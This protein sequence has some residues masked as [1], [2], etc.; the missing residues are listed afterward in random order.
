MSTQKRIPLRRLTASA[1]IAAMAAGALAVAPVATTPAAAATPVTITPNP[2]YAH[3]E[4]KGWGTSLVWFANATG[5]Y[6]LSDNAEANQLADDFYDLLFSEDGLD[7]EAVRYNIGGGNSSDTVDYLRPGG[8]VEGW[9]APDPDG[10]LGLYNGRATTYA[11]YSD[12]L[13]E[14]DPDDDAHYNFDADLS[15]RWW[16]ERLQES[17]QVKNWEFFSNSAP[18]FMTNSGYVSGHWRGSSNDQLAGNGQET[19]SAINAT[20]KFAK[21][22]ARVTRYLTEEYGIVPD[23]VEPFNEPNDCGNCW[24]TDGSAGSPQ[25]RQEGMSVKA[26]QQTRVIRELR[27]AL[28]SQ[29]LTT[30]DGKNLVSA[31]DASSSVNFRADFTGSNNGN[32]GYLQNGN[33][34]VDALGQFNTHGYGDQ[35]HARWIRDVAKSYGKPLYQS[36]F[37]GDYSGTG[38]NPYN[39]NNGLNFATRIN[40]QMAQYEPNSWALWQPVEDYYNMEQ[41]SS[42]G[43][44]NLNW[45]SIFI[46]FDCSV[47]TRENGS[48]VFASDRRVERLYGGVNAQGRVSNEVPSCTTATNSKFNTLK[49]YTHFIKAGDTVVA[50]NSADATA[51]VREAD[52]SLRVVYTNTDTTTR[53]VTLDLSGFAEIAPGATV[54]KYVTTAAPQGGPTTANTLVHDSDE[55]VTVN[56]SAKSAALEVPGRSVTTFVV[57]G[58]SGVSAEAP[59]VTDG[60][61]YQIVAQS[62]GV[63]LSANAT[64]SGV[65]VASG[66]SPISQKWTLTQV[67]VSEA[68][69][70][71]RAYVISNNNGAV[72]VGSSSGVSTTTALTVSDAIDDASAVWFLNSTDGQRFSFVNKAQI[73]ALNVS[74]TAVGLQDSNGAASQGWTVRDLSVTA[75][76]TVSVATSV[77][78]APV[79]PETVLPKY[80]WGDGAAAPVVWQLPNPSVWGQAGRVTVQGTA[81]DG[82]G[83]EFDVQALVDVGHFTLTDPASVSVSAGTTLAAVTAAA[84]TSVGARIGSSTPYPASVTWDWTGISDAAFAAVGVVTVPGTASSNEAGAPGLPAQLSVIVTT[85]QPTN[86]APLSTTTASATYTEKPEFTVDNTRNGVLTDKGWSNWRQGTQNASDTLTYEFAANEHLESAKVYFWKDGT[87]SS[88]PQSLKAQYR[89]AAGAW[90][91]VPG[92]ETAQPVTSPADGTAPVV[93]IPIGGIDATALRVVLNA[94]SNTHMIVSEVQ[95]FA[96]RRGPA[97]VASLAALRA[98]GTD[99]AGF[100]ADTL[101]YTVPVGASELAEGTFPTLTALPVDAAA[102]VTITPATTGHPTATVTVR[103]EDGTTTKAYTVTFVAGEDTLDVAGA[104]TTR[105]VAGR[106]V[107]AV[108]LTNNEDQPVAAR[109]TTAYGAKDIAALRADGSVSSAFTARVAGIPAGEATAVFTAGDRTRTLSLAYDAR[110][111]G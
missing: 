33:I 78:T 12:L 79:L 93:D 84:P 10:S 38:F 97:S 29:G 102:A 72:L 7:L 13:R 106:P 50:T 88:W 45:G 59:A 111:C 58:V 75:G 49:N 92:Y 3:Q 70:A 35:T 56:A 101:D 15:Q 53:P 40:S 46:D 24:A 48:S 57:T 47:Y 69:P 16:L 76:S 30:E 66:S 60:A 103:A 85:S 100:S 18:Y 82:F 67:P 90:V 86:I 95:I 4:F 73:K 34:W 71:D 87:A 63:P 89:T 74:G 55:N 110:T 27:A 19:D 54:E 37:E 99:I 44:E 80:S 94:R 65:S 9:W 105:C 83:T 8:A 98:G 1:T 77:G 62:S 68:R 2:W 43:G 42:T 5:H 64:G 61:G 41:P 25:A 39:F 23:T 28:D 14:W 31:M 11:N 109:V 51:A 108:T 36:E 21:Y 32:N 17:G 107:V 104:V 20:Q 52:D 91:D 81:R 26:D 96:S 6:A 22:L